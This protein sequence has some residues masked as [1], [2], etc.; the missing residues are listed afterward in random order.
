VVELI[1]Q[2]PSTIVLVDHA[3]SRAVDKG[4][5]GQIVVTGEANLEIF[6][7]VTGGGGGEGGGHDMNPPTTEPTG[8]VEDV[9]ILEGSWTTQDMDSPDEFADN[10]SPADF[11]VNILT[12]KLATTVT[13]TNNDPG[14]MHTVTDVNGAFDSGFLMTGQ[15]FSYTFDEVGEFEYYCLPH[16]WMRAKVIVEN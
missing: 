15:T 1:G 8:T 3:L 5:I 2:V 16:P 12:V 4:A 7:D 14:Q 6:E 13:W 10:E 9:A 11:S